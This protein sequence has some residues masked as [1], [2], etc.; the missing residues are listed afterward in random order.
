MNWIR[1]AASA[2]VLTTLLSNGPAWATHSYDVNCSDFQYQEDAQAWL[3]AHPGDPD[4]LD[5][6][7][8]GIA[9]ESLPHRPPPPP[10]PPPPSTAPSAP[11]NVLAK[12]KSSGAVV[13][14]NPPSSDGG[15]SITGY[16][17]SVSPGGA[18]ITTSQTT[19][20]FDGLSAPTT[21]TFNVYATNSAGNG[22]SAG[23]NAI[24]PTTF[25]DVTTTDW[26]HQH[27]QS[28]YDAGITT[29]C[30]TDASSGLKAFCPDQPVTRGEMAIF[31]LKSIGHIGDLP[32]SH[33]GYF[34]DVHAGQW[35]APYVEHLYEHGMT[36]GC[37]TFP[38]MFCPTANVSRA[39]MAVFIL[40]AL[41][42]AEHLPGYNGY[43][44]D[45]SETA[46]FRGYVEHFF[47]HGI[48][49]GCAITPR[50]YCPSAPVTRREMAVFLQR[51]WNLPIPGSVG[52]T[53]PL[54]VKFLAIG[55]GDAALYQGP[56]GEMGLIDARNGSAPEIL[57]AL[58]A[59]GSRSLKW[60]MASHYDADHIGDIVDVASSPGVTITTTY[61]RGGDRLAKD[62][63][64]Y[65]TYFDWAT[66]AT[67]LRSSLDIGSSVTLC[68]GA[69][70]V[71]FNILSAGTDGTAAGGL[72]V[73]E[74]NDKGLCVKVVYRSFDLATCGDINGSSDGSRS[75][76]E[77]AVAPAMGNVDVAKVNHHG[78]A[79]SSNQ[80]YVTTL[81]AQVA[82]VSVGSNS[83]GHPNLTSLGRW[84]SMGSVFQTQNS[85]GTMFDGDVEITTT[86]VSFFNLTTSFSS[87][88]I[89]RVLD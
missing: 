49:T 27:V 42:E 79:Y 20:I 88:N 35:F 77:S 22:P 8:D 24:V 87:K 73:S 85:D 50:R 66:G 4:G 28:I 59:T 78:S 32:T 86:G 75:D 1:L 61:D 12:A 6:D 70:Q 68:S 33:Q 76:V 11:N 54:K 48:T 82:V 71:T 65:R 45:V 34:T 16:T 10:P 58:D 47:E 52:S 64:T 21:Y 29:G 43:F 53:V 80:T 63:D 14:W 39:E 74:E 67:V 38:R 2:I 19:A 81:S 25:W 44:A 26:A 55:Q 41:G 18:S 7:K 30:S 83:Y 36:T 23:S 69:D 31:L 17:V 37:N 72:A 5:A 62:T 9:C 89:S 15:A 51:S 56:C 57:A 46:W 3:N 13:F 60:V 84:S 40:R